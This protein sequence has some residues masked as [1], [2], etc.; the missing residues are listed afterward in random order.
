MQICWII[1]AAG[2]SETTRPGKMMQ[3][4]GFRFLGSR[5]PTGKQSTE[6]T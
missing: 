1:S 2:Q 6:M 4:A 3:T 5:C